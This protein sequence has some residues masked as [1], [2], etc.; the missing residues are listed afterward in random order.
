MTPHRRRPWWQASPIDAV[1]VSDMFLRA[2]AP[3]RP[4]TT[5][6]Q[7]AQGGPRPPPVPLAP[8]RRVE[9]DDPGPLAARRLAAAQAPVPAALSE[10][11]PSADGGDSDGD[12]GA[13][14]ATT[15]DPIP[16]GPG[17]GSRS[18]SSA[19]PAGSAA[20]PRGAGL[21]GDSESDAAL[22]A[23]GAAP[24]PG[25]ACLGLGWPQ[26]WPA[27][28]EPGPTPA[29]DGRRLGLAAGAAADSEAQLGEG[30]G[31]GGLRPGMRLAA[32]NLR[33]AGDSDGPAGDSDGSEAVLFKSDPA[34]DWLPRGWC[35][36]TARRGGVPVSDSEEGC[37][38]VTQRRDAS[39]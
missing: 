14:A 34:G 6:H 21:A 36:V 38:S 9:H 28:C 24:G 31:D 18:Q 4:P 26:H 1:H 25:P 17:P 22:R 30:S 20:R 19:D 39:Q 13:G 15:C 10:S 11:L 37:Q 3:C 32:D 5:A 7:A 23:G 33:A 12:P 8:T 35:A 16:S 29:L 2:L 27:R